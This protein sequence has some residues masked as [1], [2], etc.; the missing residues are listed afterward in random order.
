MIT[1]QPTIQVAN[2][3]APGASRRSWRI[4]LLAL[5]GLLGLVAA[6]CGSDSTAT[7]SSTGASTETDSSSATTEASGSEATTGG[8]AAA[9]DECPTDFTPIKAGTLTVVTSL[10]GP[11]FW[12]GSDDDPTKI[13]GG[14]E[15]D[16][17]QAV[18][19][20]LCL[21]S[22]EV[23]NVPFDGLVAGTVTGFDV[24]FSQ[25]TI[26]DERAQ[27]VTFTEPYFEADQ[28]VLVAKGTTLATLEDAKKLRWGAQAGTTGL[29]FLTNTLEPDTDPQIFQQ[30]PDGFTALQ[31]G[32]VDAFIMD[33]P[34]VLSQAAESGGVQEVVAQF[35]TGEEYGAILPKDSTNK[36]AIDAAI[37]A[38]KDDGTLGKLAAENLGADP[39]KVPVIDVP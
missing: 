8:G 14:Y 38:L 32:Q 35:K 34:I 11:G 15:Y 33:V 2:D 12:D 6:A 29:D 13:T 25:V 19:D 3:R 16:I 21:D 28:G 1:R 30:L 26:T 18:K 4:T 10:P 39:S 20:K 23:R 17:V 36:D 37:T 24:A 9:G 5:L 7:E 22:V 27:V 31:A